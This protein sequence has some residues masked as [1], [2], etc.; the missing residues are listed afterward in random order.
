MLMGLGTVSMFAPKRM[1]TNFAIDPIGKAGLN[2]IRSLAGGLFLACVAMLIIATT[3]DQ[4][5]GYVAVALVMG[6]VAVGRIVGLIT[7]G[8]EKAVVPPLVVE[9]VIIAILLSAYT[10]L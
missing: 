1:V 6:A 5:L 3:T 8:F 4:K 2:T 7:D 10:R 9:L